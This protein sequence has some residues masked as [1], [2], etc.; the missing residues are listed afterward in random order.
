MIQT[1][2]YELYVKYMS[3]WVSGFRTQELA[4]VHRK[5]HMIELS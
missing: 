4:I 2:R 3:D 5:V 1:V